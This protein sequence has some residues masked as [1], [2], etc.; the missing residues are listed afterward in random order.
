MFQTFKHMLSPEFSLNSHVSIALLLFIFQTLS[1]SV[2]LIVF[3]FAPLLTLPSSHH[4]LTVSTKEYL[5]I[6]QGL[7]QILF[8]YSIL[9]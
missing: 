7:I 1:L 3:S 6:N 8:L 2:F 5:Y 4:Q 9:F